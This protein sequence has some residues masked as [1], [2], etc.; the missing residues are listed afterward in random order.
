MISNKCKKLLSEE[1]EQ[2]LV[3]KFCEKLNIPIK[4]SASG[5]FIKNNIGV[6]K[7][8]KALHIIE[9]KGEPDFF[10]PRVKKNK[11]GD[12]VYGGLFIEMKKIGGKPTIE[13]LERVNYYNHNGYLARVVEGHE[14]AINL[15][16]DYIKEE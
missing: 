3:V 10:I 5:I 14:N 12:I 13:Q 16:Q 1:E 6:V 15:I 4:G 7:K 8:L 11:S 9:P 2:K